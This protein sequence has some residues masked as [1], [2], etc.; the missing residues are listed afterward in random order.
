MVRKHTV[1]GWWPWKNISCRLLQKATFTTTFTTSEYSS[2]LGSKQEKNFPMWRLLDD[3]SGLTK[4]HSMTFGK[5]DFFE[6]KGE[7]SD[8]IKNGLFSKSMF[9]HTCFTVLKNNQIYL[10]LIL[11]HKTANQTIRSKNLFSLFFKGKKIIFGRFFDYVT[12][13][14]HR[15]VRLP[16]GARNLYCTILKQQ[17]L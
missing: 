11:Q 14:V 12:P 16:K 6:M 5:Q 4:Q 1:I 8:V 10:N 15:L 9:D 7:I 3:K 17:K 2:N 13:H